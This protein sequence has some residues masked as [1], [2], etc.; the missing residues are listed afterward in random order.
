MLKYTITIVACRVNI[1]LAT[2]KFEATLICDPIAV[3][4]ITKYMED[5]IL[6]G[7]DAVSL[8]NWS[9]MFGRHYAPLKYCSVMY[10]V[11]VIVIHAAMKTSRLANKLS[12]S[13]VSL[14]QILL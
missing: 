7:Y 10:Q 8:G 2:W 12:L 13:Y 3:Q 9:L 4:Y 6:L 1:V 11:N 14:T 5:P